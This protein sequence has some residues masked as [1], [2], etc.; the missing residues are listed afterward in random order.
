M[1]DFIKKTFIS[2]SIKNYRLF[3]SGQILSLIGTW[4]QRTTMSWFV[5]RLTNSAMILGLV[6]FLSMI[7][8][9]FV[10]PFVGALADGWNRHRAIIYTQIAFLVQNTILAVLVL[11]NV[12][13]ENLT[14]PIL[15]L[16]LMQG[17]IEAVD[18]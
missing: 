6:T 15:L 4:I 17:I 18:S 9:V 10:S 1:I 14:Y 16:A 8:S 2:L 3:F 11:T 7:P 5:Y 12:I 13:N